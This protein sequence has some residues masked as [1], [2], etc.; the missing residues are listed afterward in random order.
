MERGLLFALP[1]AAWAAGQDARRCLCPF[2]LNIRLR[3]AL[4]MLV[5]L[6]IAIVINWKARAQR[7]QRQM[8]KVGKGP[9][10]TMTRRNVH[11]GAEGHDEEEGEETR[12][13]QS[14]V[15]RSP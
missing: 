6:I 13:R 5:L 7:R 4:D 9:P 15:R 3:W 14:A 1:F 11:S 12:Q 10:R 2:A 8:L